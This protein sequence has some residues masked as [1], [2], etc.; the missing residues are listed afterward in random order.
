MLGHATLNLL[1]RDRVARFLLQKILEQMFDRF[2]RGFAATER[3]VG[4]N[5][6]QRAL[7]PAHVGANAIRQE[8]ENLVAQFDLQGSR[9]LAQNGETSLHRRRLEFGGQTPLETRN[10]PVLEIGDLG[11]RPI[12]GK[13][14][15][16]VAVKEGVESVKKFLL[17]AFFAAKKLNV[18]DQKQIGLAIAL[19]ELDQIAVLDRIDEFVDEKLARKINHLGVFLFS[20]HELSDRLH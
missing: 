5:P 10:Q 9:F 20:E 2:G 18:V 7:Q 16:L 4:R 8:F 19:S 3:G 14:N 12:A 13:D 17:R 11:G 1:D 6:D 15:L